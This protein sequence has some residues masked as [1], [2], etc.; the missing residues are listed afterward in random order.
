MT[1]GSV[2]D[3]FAQIFSG[4]AIMRFPPAL[5]RFVLAFRMPGIEPRRRVTPANAINMA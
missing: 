2:I 3:G 4:L 5:V 1:V